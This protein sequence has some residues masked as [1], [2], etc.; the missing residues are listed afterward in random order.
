VTNERNIIILAGKGDENK[1][2]IKTTKSNSSD[3]TQ[4]NT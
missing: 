1:Y 4:L 2:T 3:T